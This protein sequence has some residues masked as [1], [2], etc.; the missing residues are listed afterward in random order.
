MP[1]RPRRRTSLARRAVT[2]TMVVVVCALAATGG[3]VGGQVLADREEEPISIR[4]VAGGSTEVVELVGPQTVTSVLIMGGV[5]PRPGRLLSRV[6]H[7]VIDPALNPPLITVGGQPAEDGTPVLDGMTVEVTKG[8]DEVEGATEAIVEL[9]APPLPDVMR[10]VHR[11][12]RSGQ[13]R[14]VR[15]TISGELVSRTVLAEPVAPAQVTDKV[16]ALTFDD[17]PSEIWTQAMMAVLAEK[18]VLATFCT[19]GDNVN[20]HPEIARTVAAAGHQLCNHTQSHVLDLGSTNADQLEAQM[21][22]GRQ[23][24]VDAGLPD[25]P[26]YRPP[27]GSLSDQVSAEARERS[28]AVLYWKVDTED[29]RTTADPLKILAKVQEQTDPGAIIL[30]HDGGGKNRAISVLTLGLVIDWLRSEGYSFVF[31][32]LDAP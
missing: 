12:G 9:P 17:G 7:S 21:D 11:R 3:V 15:G 31:P 28:E 26:Y 13:A 6:S 1:R 2:I 25:P 32:L 18:G 8:S 30:M 24:I 4:L 27:G 16:V 14:E 22:G 20:R 23:A 19:V 29:W 10:H 5:V